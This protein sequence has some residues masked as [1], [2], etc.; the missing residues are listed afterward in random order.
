MK[1]I[2][3]DVPTSLLLLMG[4]FVLMFFSCYGV[5]IISDV[6]RLEAQ[7]T[8]ELC[9]NQKYYYLYDGKVT[10]SDNQVTV[11]GDGVDISEAV[12]IC[13]SDNLNIAFRLFFPFENV[14][15][16]NR[17]NEYGSDILDVYVSY[18]GDS[19][20]KSDKAN[21][22]Y[23]NETHK[24]LAT[25]DKIELLATKYNVIGTINGR[26]SGIVMYDNLDEEARFSL[27][28]HTK[29]YGRIQVVIG[30]DSDID[31]QEVERIQKELSDNGFTLME[32]KDKVFLDKE[33]SLS[34]NSGP[35]ICVVGMIFTLITLYI[36]VK[37][38]FVK[39]VENVAIIWCHGESKNGIFVFLAKEI[40]IIYGLAVV[41][42]TFVSCIYIL[43]VRSMPIIYIPIA[44]VAAYMLLIAVAYVMY[45]SCYRKL[46]MLS[47]I[48]G[49]VE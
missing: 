46:S 33:E 24:S 40:S 37:L 41:I 26:M 49:G 45:D 3:R 28:K 39:R 5:S 29:K 25:G 22:I 16:S 31:M 6:R 34:T 48:S 15:Y 36:L 44:I 30:S 1:K 42:F 14:M 12:K 17:L 9:K 8:K 2:L 32:T 19:L 4:I 7:R 43:C 21:A 23:L 11:E 10:I 18:N 47:V 27:L 38:W 35:I 13:K 20:E